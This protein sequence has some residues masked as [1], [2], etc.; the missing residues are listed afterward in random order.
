MNKFTITKFQNKEDNETI[1]NPFNKNNVEITKVDVMNILEKGGIKHSI[2][3]LDL[4]IKAFTHK[5]YSIDKNNDQLNKYK[6]LT[7]A[8]KPN[9]V[10]D[11]K[12]FSNERLEFLGDSILGAVVTSYLFIRYFDQN[13]GF[14]TKLKTK[15]VNTKALSN[16][17]RHLELNKFIIMSEQVENKNNGRNSDKILEDTF[18]AL[19]GAMFLDF[20]DNKT[21]VD[22]K[23]DEI[24]GIGYQICEKFI[25]HIIENEVDLEELILKDTN[26]KDQLLRYYQHNF[27]V[28][29]FYKEIKMD[30]PPHKRL[31]TMA[32]LDKNGKVF[33]TATNKTKKQAEQL[34]SKNALIKFGELDFGYDKD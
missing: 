13:E 25:L 8:K 11:L 4:Y 24:S 15:L 28:T 21:L 30:G 16:F 6:N 9:Y 19:I 14:M 31:F 3:H 1:L 5:S 18:E 10:L 33:S 26:Y 7:L 23:F 32:V 27:Q 29:P 12:N 22:F 34:A 2:T 17:A 20:N